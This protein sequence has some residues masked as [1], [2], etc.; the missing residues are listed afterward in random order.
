MKKLNWKTIVIIVILVLILIL[1]TG[2]TD[3]PDKKK[4]TDEVI[5]ILLDDD[6]IRLSGLAIEYENKITCYW[7]FWREGYR[8]ANLSGVNIQATVTQEGEA[9]KTYKAQIDNEGFALIEVE[10]P[11]IGKKYTFKLLTVGGKEFKPIKSE[12]L[13]YI[14]LEITLNGKTVTLK[15]PFAQLIF[16][17]NGQKMLEFSWKIDEISDPQESL[18][19]LSIY[20]KAK[21]IKPDGSSYTTVTKTKGEGLVWIHVP[22]SNKHVEKKYVAFIEGVAD[23]QAHLYNYSGYGNLISWIVEESGAIVVKKGIFNITDAQSKKEELCFYWKFEVEGE[24]PVQKTVYL[25]VRDKNSNGE[26]YRVEWTRT[27]NENGEIIE[28]VG[29]RRYDTTITI[30]SFKDENIIYEGDGDSLHY[31]K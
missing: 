21:V 9:H 11:E 27:T 2:C 19:N 8:P 25:D 18:E 10:Q 1:I 31:L 17:E 23:A 6:D 4:E 30:K 14:T 7:R 20:L 29:D 24:N 12:D 22:Y 28:P 16:D 5:D 3:Y 26:D 13:E 15:E